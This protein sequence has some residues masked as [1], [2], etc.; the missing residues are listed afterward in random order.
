MPITVTESIKSSLNP[1]RRWNWALIGE[2]RGNWTINMIEFE[3]T[4]GM[5]NT[6]NGI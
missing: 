5:K 2:R 6:V 4:E 1:K 3:L